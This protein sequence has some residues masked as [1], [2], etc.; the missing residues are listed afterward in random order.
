MHALIS[1]LDR[2]HAGARRSSVLRRLAIVSRILLAMAFIPTGLVK[3]LGERFTTL[4]VENPIGFFFEAMYRSGWYWNFL[5][6][7]QVLAGLLLLVPFTSTLGALLFLPIVV[8]ITAIT[9]SVG[10]SGTIYVTALMLLAN[11][12]LV[13]WDYD[14]WKG[15]LFEPAERPTVPAYA[16]L[17]TIERVGYAIGTVAGMALLMGTRGLSRVSVLVPALAVGALA[18]VLVVIGWVQSGRGARVATVR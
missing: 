9:W 8:N 5:G 2:L 6:A 12:F 1:S 3:L 17:P 14:R 11:V 16:P 13:C 4:P 7:G 10:F 18:A 15:I